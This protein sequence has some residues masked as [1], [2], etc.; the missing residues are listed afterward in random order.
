MLRRVGNLKCGENATVTDVF[1]A[2]LPYSADRNTLS[3]ERAQAEKK[4]LS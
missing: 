2:T 4:I 3:F 1:K